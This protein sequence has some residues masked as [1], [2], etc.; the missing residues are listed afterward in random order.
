VVKIY[1][2]TVHLQISVGFSIANQQ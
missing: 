1:T 2:P